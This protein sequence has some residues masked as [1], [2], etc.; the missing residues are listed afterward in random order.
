MSIIYRDNGEVKEMD[1]EVIVIEDGSST[2]YRMEKAI[3]SD[4]YFSEKS[5]NYITKYDSG[6]VRD[7]RTGKSRFDLI[8]PEDVPYEEQILTRWAN[9]MAKG[10]EHYGERNWE[11]AHG[12]DEYDDFRESAFRHFMQW[13]CGNTDVDHA[14]AVMFNITGAERLK[15]RI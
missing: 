15:G 3:L 8:M 5:K 12:I 13:F 9:L 7:S 2:I 14:V 6:M 10:A 11:K 4:V 1:D